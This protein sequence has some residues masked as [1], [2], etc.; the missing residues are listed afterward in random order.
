MIVITSA[1]FVARTGA[2][3]SR[4]SKTWRPQ[5]EDLLNGFAF[6]LYLALNIFYLVHV[7]LM[8][9]VS[10]YLQGKRPAYAEL[11]SDAK[12]FTVIPL[13]NT[14]LLFAELWLVKLAFLFLYRKSTV[15]CLHLLQRLRFT[16]HHWQ[17]RWRF[18]MYTDNWTGKLMVGLPTYMR[19]WYF[20]L[21]CC[22]V[23][24]LQMVLSEK[25]S[26]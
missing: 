17:K 12:E 5:T 14:C 23:V 20:V 9:R 19:W 10:D 15:P 25:L 4:L 13:V 6:G 16:L 8:Y 18:A 1:F 21:V 22:L 2:R 11:L 26:H 3:L 24:R 7:E